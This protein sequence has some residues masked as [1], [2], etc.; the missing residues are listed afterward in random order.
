MRRLI[1]QD[2][3]VYTTYSSRRGSAQL[4]LV[5]ENH[6]PFGGN[7]V[8]NPG[9]GSE[10]LLAPLYVSGRG[11]AIPVYHAVFTANLML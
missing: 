2:V 9:P 6:C 10:Y 4:M 11:D 1:V 7:R 8:A 3:P 5:L